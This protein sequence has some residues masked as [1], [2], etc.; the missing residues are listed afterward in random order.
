MIR[1]ELL[2]AQSLPMVGQDLGGITIGNRIP[3]D[4]FE[5]K[6]SGESDITIHAGSYH[7]ALRE[8]GIEMCNIMTYSSILPGI[9][10]RIE[11]PAQITHGAVMESIMSVCHADKGQ[12]ASSGIIYGWLHNKKTHEKFGG[13][14]C[15]HYGDYS[16]DDL[17]YRL[18]ASLEELYENGFSDMY[19]LKT[20]HTLLQTFVPKKRHG[21]A[22]VSLCF[23]TYYCP[24]IRTSM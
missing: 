11:K 22:L 3:K 1:Q 19:D 7:L 6:G 20:P 9:A 16:V 18:E 4:Y 15:E 10:Q 14:V 21:T 8:A 5:T 12:R 2:K 23:T 13:L 24:I 17:N